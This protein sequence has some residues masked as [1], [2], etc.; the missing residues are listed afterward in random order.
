VNSEPAVDATDLRSSDSFSGFY[1]AH[2][3]AVYGYLF[4]LCAG[5][6]DLAEDLT[7]DTWMALARELRRA[8]TNAPTSAG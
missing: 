6:R 3:P 2:L 1:H 8:A 4:R 5:D 7:Q